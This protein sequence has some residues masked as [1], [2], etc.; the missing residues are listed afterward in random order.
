[1]G[2]R[3]EVTVIETV[4]LEKTA[5][6]QEALLAA[7]LSNGEFD[8]VSERA[9]NGGGSYGLVDIGADEIAAIEGRYEDLL[10][11]YDETARTDALIELPG[12]WFVV[13]AGDKVTRA[14]RFGDSESAISAF[15]QWSG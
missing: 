15:E 13:V 7:M 1:M 8:E 2:K 10:G 9:D 3:Y 11:W 14:D 12:S 6:V 5:E 4:H